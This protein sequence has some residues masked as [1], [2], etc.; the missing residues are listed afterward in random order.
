MYLP[1]LAAVQHV[2]ILAS[3]LIQTAPEGVYQPH[4]ACSPIVKA[5]STNIGPTIAVAG[6]GEAVLR[7]NT[8]SPPL[9]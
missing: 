9:S 4:N 2:C 6:L 7:N 3:Y 8:L 5:T 1:C